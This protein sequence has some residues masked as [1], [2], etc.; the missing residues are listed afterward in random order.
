MSPF[1]EQSNKPGLFDLKMGGCSKLE[2][3]ESTDAAGGREV[4]GG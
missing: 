3:G 2:A 1:L 4:V